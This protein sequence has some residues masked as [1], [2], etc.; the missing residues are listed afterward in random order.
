VAAWPAR[1]GVRVRMVDVVQEHVQ[2]CREALRRLRIEGRVAQF[3]QHVDGLP[4]A[5]GGGA[6]RLHPAG[7]EGA[8][9][10]LARAR[11]AAALAR[12]PMAWRCR[13][14]TGLN[15]RRIAQAA[16]PARTVAAS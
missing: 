5:A 6:A 16:G 1:A 7:G 8:A 15:E 9:D 2:A 4:A 14:R 12:R 11:A 10:G 3:V 13:C